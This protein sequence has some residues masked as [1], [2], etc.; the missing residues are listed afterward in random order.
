MGGFFHDYNHGEWTK[1]FNLEDRIA[2][3]FLFELRIFFKSITKYKP[4]G[5]TYTFSFR[6][7]Y[8]QWNVT[9]V[10]PIEY[11]SC[12]VTYE[13]ISPPVACQRVAVSFLLTD[14][15][16]LL[17]T[18]QTTERRALHSTKAIKQDAVI[19]IQWLFDKLLMATGP[20][21]KRWMTTLDYR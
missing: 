11:W 9:F 12:T 13:S 19:A 20:Y 10:L 1:P 21:W 18:L 6:W 17:Q 5:N 15:S 4:I 2:L 16:V 7:Y 8:S 3:E 14:K